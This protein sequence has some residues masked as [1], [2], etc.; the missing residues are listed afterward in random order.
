MLDPNL[1]RSHAAQTA[2]RLKAT[3]GFVL[4]VAVLDALESER[5]QLQTRTQELQNLR[6]TRS[7]AIG[8]AKAKGEDASALLAEVAGFG[9][10][11]KACATRLEALSDAL[12]AIALG[13]PNQI[14]SA[15]GRGRVCQYG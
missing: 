6:N 11:L 13:I 9:D 1:L 2:E 12:A 14:G 10:D 7:K 15:S 8:H 5:K 3:R 4:D